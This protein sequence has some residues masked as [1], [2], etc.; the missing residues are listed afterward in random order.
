M[1]RD[2]LESPP[3]KSLA[4]N[5]WPQ[6]AIQLIALVGFVVAI[7]AGLFGTPVGN[8]NF[9]I[10]F[11]WIVW[12][13][14]LMLVL[15]PLLGRAWCSICPIPAPGE[16]LQRGAILTPQRGE[17]PWNRR[18]I[19]G[20]RWPR[21]FRNIWLQNIS[22]SLLALFSLVVLTDPGI[23]A[24]VL[25]A[26]L[27]LAIVTSIIF[28]RR[29]FCR[30]LCPVGGF[31]GLYSQV[32]PVELRVKDH[33]VCK[34]HAVKTCYTG[35]SE[36]YGCPWQ[37][38]PGS[39]SKNTSCGMCMEC[40]RTCPFDNIAINIRSFGSDLN[41]YTNR[42]LDEAYKS[43][44]MLG[45]ALVYSVVMLGPW[46]SL[47]S[48][49]Y[50]IGSLPWMFYV[51]TFVAFVYLLI[52]GL[53]F[54]ATSAGR[55]LSRSIIPTRKVF[56]NF[57]YAIVPLGLAGWISFSLSFVFANFSYVWPVLSDPFGWGWNL[58]ATA[59]EMWNPY[60][61]NVTPYLQ[62]LALLTGLG[63]TTALVKRLALT[64]TPPLYANRQA[65]PV[66][67]FSLLITFA[68]VWILVL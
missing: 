25:L 21:R 20:L 37:V 23:T 54:L 4:T 53:F 2:I 9:A 38:Y 51:L 43:F 45:S 3:V 29:A 40:L 5:R 62:I 35:S 1:G 24:W 13:A 58:F 8:R 64:T 28:E 67:I 68:F 48:A 50:A 32:A 12:W 11:V 55:V 18:F 19:F 63:W 14:L 16:W 46:G 7:M 57:A 10:V 15:A 42:K 33:A 52:P 41:Q 6:F 34:S 49:A 65:L 66:M 22:F 44:I 47:K 27:L 31:I 36:G 56:I 17:K 39:L 59:G 30:Y 26:F 60:L 61:T